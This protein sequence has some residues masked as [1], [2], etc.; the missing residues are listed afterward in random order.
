M[1]KS[2]ATSDCFAKQQLLLAGDLRV[3][4]DE[5]WR[6]SKTLLTNAF[7]FGSPP[8]QIKSSNQN[9]PVN[10]VTK[11]DD[12]QALVDDAIDWAHNICYIMRTPEQLDRSDKAQF[13]PFALFPS[14][15]PRKFYEQALAVQKL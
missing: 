9:L 13:T 5:L 4:H 14:P 2:R 1:T 10:V 8:T 7:V 3:Y 15:I 6:P 11:S 12:I